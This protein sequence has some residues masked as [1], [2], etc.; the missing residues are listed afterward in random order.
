MDGFVKVSLKNLITNI[1]EDNVKNILSDFFCPLNNDI[2]YFLKSKAVE[3]EKQGI[4]RTQLI[5][6]SYREKSVLIGY[7][8]LA[9][10]VFIVSSKMSI[11]NSLR[12]KINKFATYYPESKSYMLPAPLIAQLGKNFANDYNKLISGDELLNMAIED[13]KL[14]R[15]LLGGKV[16]YLECEDKPK[17]ID[18]YK[19]NGFVRFGTRT[20]DRDETQL[21]GEYLVQ[22]LKY[23]E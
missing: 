14:T 17:L 20:L 18:F 9:E 21:T 23:I 3:F 4:S 2:E 15:Q 13:I 22:M 16:A 7:Y 5:Y 12:K 6:A 10:K 8:T 11:S 19:D 1:G